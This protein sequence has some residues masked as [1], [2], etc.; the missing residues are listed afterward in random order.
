VISRGGLHCIEEK[1]SCKVLIFLLS[2][3]GAFF[4]S[5]FEMVTRGVARVVTRG[6]V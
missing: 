5:M 6:L 3:E 1:A 4:M 2:W